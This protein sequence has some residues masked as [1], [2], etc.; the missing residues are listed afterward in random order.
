MWLAC[1]GNAMFLLRKEKR[2]VGILEMV[3]QCNSSVYMRTGNLRISRAIRGV[4][5]S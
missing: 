3:G 1:V 5:C 4:W 2:S